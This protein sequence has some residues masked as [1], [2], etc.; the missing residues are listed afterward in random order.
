[1]EYVIIEQKSDESLK[2]PL[3]N[4]TPEETH[5]ANDFLPILTE[6]YRDIPRDDDDGEINLDKSLNFMEDFY[7]YA[8]LY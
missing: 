1:M 2:A 7:A 8:F 4:E 3:A 5:L 6:A